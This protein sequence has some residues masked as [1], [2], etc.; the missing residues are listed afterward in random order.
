VATVSEALMSPMSP[1]KRL[2]AQIG[3]APV[4]LLSE[5]QAELLS[6]SADD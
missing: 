5:G 4:C 3:L 6:G 1:R 2:V